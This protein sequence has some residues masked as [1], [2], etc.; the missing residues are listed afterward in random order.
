MLVKGPLSSTIMLFQLMTDSPKGTKPLITCN[1]IH[2]IQIDSKIQIM[3][4]R[5]Y[6]WYVEDF[7]IKKYQKLFLHA[8]LFPSGLSFWIAW[9]VGCFV[10]LSRTDYQ[11]KDNGQHTG[12]VIPRFVEPSWGKLTFTLH[13]FNYMYKN[14]EINVIYINN[15]SFQTDWHQLP[16]HNYRMIWYF[17]YVACVMIVSHAY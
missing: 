5:C 13:K 14:T 3:V 12:S 7:A 4:S 8:I 10:Q 17:W 11:D 2:I 1:D 15:Y 16:L 6:F 9:N